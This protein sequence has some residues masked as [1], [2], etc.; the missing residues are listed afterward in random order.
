MKHSARFTLIE[1]AIAIAVFAIGILTA[2][3]ILVP[4]VRWGA[5]AKTDFTAAE[6]ALNL[7]QTANNTGVVGIY[8][9]PG[10]ATQTQFYPYVAAFYSLG[11]SPTLIST[12]TPGSEE[13]GVVK[14]YRKLPADPFVTNGSNLAQYTN[15]AD[16]NGMVVGRDGKA[17]ALKD[18]EPIFE[19]NVNLLQL[20]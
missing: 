8:Q 16:E 7:M 13:E 20:P 9:G 5:D 1:I 12:I 18:A 17:K 4:S 14:V 15:P 6:A 19:M 2:M 10:T 3:A 11:T